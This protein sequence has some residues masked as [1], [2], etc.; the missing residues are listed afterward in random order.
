MPRYG[1]CHDHGRRGPRD[2]GNMIP[3]YEQ[4]GITIYHG[5]CREILPELGPVDLVLTDPPY[6]MNLDTDYSGF[7]GWGGK[8]KEWDRVIG[9]DAPFDPSPWLAFPNAVLWG[10][11]FYASKLPDNGAWL[12]FNKR[13]DGKTNLFWRLRIS[14][15]LTRKEVGSHV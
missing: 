10:A 15:D 9:D 1:D 3:Y 11:N 5:D 13:G 6:G 12:V 7:N 4:D 14:V 8:G 2:R